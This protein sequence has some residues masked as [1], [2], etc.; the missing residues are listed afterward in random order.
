[1]TGQEYCGQKILD[2][3]EAHSITL[4]ELLAMRDD[5]NARLQEK[6]GRKPDSGFAI[7]VSSFSDKLSFCG[8]FPDLRPGGGGA[9]VYGHELRETPIEAY[10]HAIEAIENFKAP[11]K[12]DKID[13]LKKQIEELEN[14]N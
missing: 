10:N 4:G 13:E 14:E 5:L 6:L 2:R 11:S 1:M 9:V 3:E 12:Q 8:A 7:E